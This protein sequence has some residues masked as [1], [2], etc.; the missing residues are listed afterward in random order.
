MKKAFIIAGIAIAVFAAGFIA[1]WSI[2]RMRDFQF[3]GELVASV[4]C[5]S[6]VVALT[7]DDGPVPIHTEEALAIL[8]ANGIRA[9]FFLNGIG[10]EKHPELGKAIADAG[11]DIG[12]HTYTHATLI[13]TSPDFIADEIERTDRLIRATGYTNRILFRP[14]HGKKLLLLPLYLAQHGRIS[15]TWDIEPDSDSRIEA[16]PKLILSDITNRVRN[17]SII[18]L[19]IMYSSRSNTVK[20]LRQVIP[21]VQKM[22]YRFVTLTELLAMRKR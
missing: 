4:P 1:V 2:S 14:P 13:F 5:E 18:L 16:D 19:H 3:F 17:G 22:G 20:A 6:K 9:T 12:N 8:A 21:A 10:L 7:F 15:V 11:H